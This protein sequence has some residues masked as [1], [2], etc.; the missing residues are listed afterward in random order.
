MNDHAPSIRQILMNIQDAISVGK[1]NIT[2]KH[3][4]CQLIHM[5]RGIN[6]P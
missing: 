3:T 2:N 1:Q 6:K 4:R 5:P